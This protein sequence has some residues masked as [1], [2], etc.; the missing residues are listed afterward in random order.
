M[1][2]IFT[3][4]RLSNYSEFAMEKTLNYSFRV[5]RPLRVHADGKAQVPVSEGPLADESEILTFRF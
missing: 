1:A 5:K 4:S 3:I 2:A